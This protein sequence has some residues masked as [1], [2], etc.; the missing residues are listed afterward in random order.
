MLPQ[1]QQ[2]VANLPLVSSEVRFTGGL[3]WPVLEAAAATAAARCC[4]PFRSEIWSIWDVRRRG[5]WGTSLNCF[6]LTVLT[7]DTMHSWCVRMNAAVITC[8]SV[9]SVCWQAIGRWP[10]R[11]QAR[12][13]L[14]VPR[15]KESNTCTNID[16]TPRRDANYYA[17][18]V[19]V[20]VFVCAL[21]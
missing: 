17:R 9:F 6:G 18:I 12:R 2:T 14:S 5:S 10:Q 7:I 3:L 21:T 8:K 1:S 15:D 20:R 4:Q 13:A 11:T 19:C 16:T